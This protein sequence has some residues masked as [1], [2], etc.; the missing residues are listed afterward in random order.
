MNS[1]AV[2]CEVLFIVS[3]LMVFFVL[4]IP[5]MFSLQLKR[6]V[7][8]VGMNRLRKLLNTE[9]LI[10]KAENLDEVNRQV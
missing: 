9:K 4:Q 7:S 6:G 3:L 1:V 2:L 10:F 5:A 8:G